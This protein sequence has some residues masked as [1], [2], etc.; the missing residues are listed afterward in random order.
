V[1]R[2][3]VE[4][5]FKTTGFENGGQKSPID[6]SE[7]KLELDEIKYRAQMFMPSG[8]DIHTIPHLLKAKDLNDTSNHG[9][10]QHGG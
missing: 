3:G 4:P 5:F 1:E 9:Q 7:L 2:E 10:S 8:H 6:Q